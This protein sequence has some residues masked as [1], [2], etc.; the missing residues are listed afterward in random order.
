M[1][2][3]TISEVGVLVDKNLT[4]GNTAS[5]ITKNSHKNDQRIEKIPNPIPPPRLAEMI[6]LT[7]NAMMSDGTNV[8]IAIEKSS[9]AAVWNSFSKSA[10]KDIYTP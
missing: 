4:D 8:I 1:S 9:H 3:A 2:P 7:S 5:K 10:P 6:I